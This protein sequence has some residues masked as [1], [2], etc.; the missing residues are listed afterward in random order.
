VNRRLLFTSYA[1][2]G[3]IEA[4]A[5]FYAYFTV[6]ST[7]GWQWGDVLGPGE[8]LYLKGIS[9]FFAAIVVCQVA[10]AFMSKTHRQS[11]LRQG[12][13]ANR[14]LLVGIG[15]ELALAVSI[16]GLEPLHTLFG[17]ASLTVGEFLLAW[18]FAVGMLLL[19][20]LRRLLIRMN[21]GWVTR[22][23]GS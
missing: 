18:P 5:G 19:D 2:H 7:G 10:N 8:P 17:N 23:T 21:V 6:L 13:C 20:E 16:I 14:W 15:V 1:L 4:A 9:A 3:V 12:I 22:L 11:L